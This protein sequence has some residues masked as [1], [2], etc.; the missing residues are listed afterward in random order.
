M[1][2]AQDR[3]MAA[4]DKPSPALCDKRVSSK[5]GFASL[6]EESSRERAGSRSSFLRKVLSHSESDNSV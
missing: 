5:R 3:C 6:R 2:L 1:L 4:P